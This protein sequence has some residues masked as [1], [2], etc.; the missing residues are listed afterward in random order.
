[1]KNPPILDQ[2]ERE[3]GYFDDDG[4]P[5][6]LTAAEVDELNKPK[7]DPDPKPEGTP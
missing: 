3:I 1:M 6:Y 7:P 5:V 4:K 2:H